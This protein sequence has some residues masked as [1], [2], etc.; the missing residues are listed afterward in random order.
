VPA[1]DLWEAAASWF[2]AMADVAM[3]I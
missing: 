1:T 3:E 2:E